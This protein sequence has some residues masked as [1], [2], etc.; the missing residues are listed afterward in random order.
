MR[1][2]EKDRRNATKQQW[3]QI[4]LVLDRFLFIL[5]ATGTLLISLIIIYQRQVS[6]FLGL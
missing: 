5:F 3:H 4:A 1:L 2:A 6:L